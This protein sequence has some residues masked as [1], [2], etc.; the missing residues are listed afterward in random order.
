[1]V[2]YA[3][4]VAFAAKRQ[5]AEAS[6]SLRT[7]TAAAAKQSNPILKPTL[8]IAQHALLGEIARRQSEWHEAEGHFRAAMA[9]EDGLSYMEPP[10]WYYPIR[11][12]L[13][14]VLLRGGKAVE[15][16]RIYRQDLTRFPNNGWS[17]YGLW[18]SLLAQKKPAMAGEVE[19]QFKAAWAKAD[20]ILDGSRL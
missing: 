1:M 11:H 3:R 20:L 10:W 12:S 16:E 8:E 9:L 13:G 2:D 6:A 15:A 17:L 19:R 14:L 4:G 18:R 5:W 7:V